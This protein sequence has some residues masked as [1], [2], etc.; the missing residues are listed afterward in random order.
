MAGDWLCA[1]VSKELGHNSI[2]QNTRNSLYFSL[3]G[4][5]FAPGESRV[6]AR[7]RPPPPARPLFG[8][9]GLNQAP[10]VVAL[11]AD[12][13]GR[14]QLEARVGAAGAAGGVL[15][16]LLGLGQDLL[17]A[18]HAVDPGRDRGGHERNVGEQARNRAAKGQLLHASCDRDHAE[19]NADEPSVALDQAALVP[20]HEAKTANAVGGIPATMQISPSRPNLKAS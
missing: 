5:E 4:R 8:L 15:A 2:W 17:V 19:N 7:L 11:T 9:T 10:F 16:K 1:W 6:R 14:D 13:R 12:P 3:L 20:A 18:Q